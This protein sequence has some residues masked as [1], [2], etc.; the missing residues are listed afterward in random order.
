MPSMVA[1]SA[2]STPWSWC[3]CAVAA[4][5]AD[6]VLAVSTVATSICTRWASGNPQVTR[7]F[8]VWS[9]WKEA[10]DSGTWYWTRSSMGMLLA[11]EQF[12]APRV[13]ML[14]AVLTSWLAPGLDLLQRG[15]RL[16][17][18]AGA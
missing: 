17:D 6:G 13:A 16:A 5:I 10:S 4:W 1:R 9:R 14:T 15:E 18:A 3:S 8:T 7:S 11:G 2:S 12:A